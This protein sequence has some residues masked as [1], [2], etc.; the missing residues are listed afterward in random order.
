MTTQW[1]HPLLPSSHLTTFSMTPFLLLLTYIVTKGII[2]NMVTRKNN[3]IL[4][5]M[6]VQFLVHH[7]VHLITLKTYRSLLLLLVQFLVHLLVHFIVL[8]TSYSRSLRKLLKTT[9]ISVLLSDYT[10]NF[11]YSIHRHSLIVAQRQDVN[12]GNNAQCNH[13]ISDRDQFLSLNEAMNG[14]D[15][16][17]FMIVMNKETRTSASSVSIL[18]DKVG[19]SDRGYIHILVKIIKSHDND[20]IK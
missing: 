11:L 13:S 1:M 8:T 4:A 12:T 3:Y 18:G 6:L 19:M 17:G 5:P 15:S 10:D 2:M 14:P 20:L 16:F 9:D 7:L